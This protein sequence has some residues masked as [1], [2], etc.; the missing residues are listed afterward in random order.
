MDLYDNIANALNKKG[1]NVAI[2]NMYDAMSIWKQYWRG[3]VNDFHFY[4][5]K[6][7][8]GT[9]KTCERL[10]MNMAKKVSE[11][12]A[13][14]LWTE[15][16]QIQLSNKKATERLW[17]VLDSKENS[18]TIN[19][20]IFIEKVCA[21]GSG[22]LVEYKKE[23]KTIIDYIDGDCIIPYKY[24]NG[25]INGVISVST[26]IEKAGEDT[27]YYSHLMYHEFDGV[28]YTRYNELYVSNVENELGEEIEFS[29]K[30]PNVIN[31]YIIKTDTPH[32]QVVRPNLANNY[33]CNTPMGLSVYANSLDKLK[34]IDLK[35]DS[36]MREFDLGRKRI[37]V[38]RAALKAQV[39]VDENGKTSMVQYF[40]SNDQAY[41]AIN[42]ME[43]QPV[44]EIDF[45]L[46]TQEHIDA[47]NADLNWLSSGVGL[48]QNFY[49]FDGKEVKTATEVI[50]ENSDTFRTREHHWLII[51]DAIYDLV[52]AV[53]ELEGIQTKSI[54]I[55]S[56]DSIIEDKNAKEL[57]AMQKVSQGLSSKKKFLIDVEGM[58]EDE[59]QKEL[60]EI[61]NEK[62]SNAEMFGVK[63]E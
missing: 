15:K 50:S 24:T 44:K 12:F 42:G 55:I 46:R 47:I 51:H 29:V 57:R 26:F 27:L 22:M 20:P 3:S 61:A 8:N 56:D 52:K 63:E 48:G 39:N 11:D 25:Y 59:A 5:V 62:Q 9:T 16:T 36:F 33:D 30:Y 1:I 37:L 2:G 28:N 19:L 45:T 21:L 31:P 49:K 41:V 18:L 14:L 53:C 40:D 32:F 17:S 13:K 60:Q 23:G 54:S 43:G 10:T 4:N 58:T 34:S 6:L 35:Y 38:D 7:A